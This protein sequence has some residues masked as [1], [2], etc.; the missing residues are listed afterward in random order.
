MKP[1]PSQSNVSLDPATLEAPE[2]SETDPV[3]GMKVAPNPAKSVEHES[4]RYYFCSARCIEKFRS[5]PS[6]HVAVHPK[7]AEAPPSKRAIYTC[8]MHPEVRQIG[9]GNCPICGRALEPLEA[10]SEE[11]DGEL[12]D[13]TRRFWISVALTAP[14]LAITMSE[15]VPGLDLYHRIGATTN[16]WMQ[17]LLATPVVVWGGWPFFA[18]AWASFR[19]W[20]LNMFSLIGLGTGAAF[21]FS[22]AALLFPTALPDA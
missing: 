3:C 12:R 13:M 6:Q 9:P 11:D 15:L 8:P 4:R 2:K 19:T 7:A 16:D 18:R 22:V 17:A 10:T 20:R 21:L 14:L 5:N 1:S